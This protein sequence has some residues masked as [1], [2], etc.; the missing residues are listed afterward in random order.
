[1]IIICRR[2]ALLVLAALVLIAPASAHGARTLTSHRVADSARWLGAIDARTAAYATRATGGAAVLRT[3]VGQVSVVPSPAGCDVTA[4]GA[5]RIV[6]M[7]GDWYALPGSGSPPL[8]SD[9]A[10]TDAAGGNR[11]RVRQTIPSTSEVPPGGPTAVGAEWILTAWNVHSDSWTNIY[12]NW[13]TGETRE[14]EPLDPRH[15]DDLDAPGLAGELCSPLRATVVP[16]DQPAYGFRMLPVT[17]RGAWVL[18]VRAQDDSTPLHGRHASLYRCGSAKAIRLPAGFHP[19]ALGDG[20]AADSLDGTLLRLA[21]RR[22]FRVSA[23]RGVMHLTH[24][25]AYVA[26]PAVGELRTVLL[27]RAD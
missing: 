27:P 13:H 11:V 20:W 16:A 14:G 4:A 9:V 7:C 2:L 12:T 17:Q 19:D 15:P 10:V 24:G 25:R 18:I 5:R 8:A 23:P 6:S 21:D 3:D 26:N 22:V 1:M